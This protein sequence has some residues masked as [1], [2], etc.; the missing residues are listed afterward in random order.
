MIIAS[1]RLVA[2]SAFLMALS[3]SVFAQSSTPC[4]EGR[5]ANGACVNADLAQDLR[6][7]TLVLSQPKLSMTNPPVLPAQDGQ[8]D[9]P[10]DHHEIRNLHGYPP[11]TSAAG[12]TR[13]FIG[14]CL[15][16]PC[17]IT[18]NTGPQP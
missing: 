8:Y 2:T 12:G 1:S 13:S 3:G 11:V 7:S 15:A 16:A 14:V 5:T 6:T 10:R 18:V 17:T 4:S 9:I